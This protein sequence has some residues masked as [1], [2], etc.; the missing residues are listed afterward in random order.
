MD[1]PINVDLPQAI[2]IP[3]EYVPDQKVRIRLYRRMAEIPD[4]SSLD[5]F[6]EELID[7]FGPLPEAVKNLIFQIRVKIRGKRA[8]LAS[9]GVEAG[10]IV[11]RFPSAGNKKT[12]KRFHDLDADVR[13]GKNSYWCT[14][15]RNPNWQERLLSV[16]DTLALNKPALF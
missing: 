14:F 10:Q 6:E 7:R 11:L 8:N 9:I 2:S 5:A 12:A 15:G 16:L 4:E 1:I 13:G 3:N